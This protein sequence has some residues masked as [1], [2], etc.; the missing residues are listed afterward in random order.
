MLYVIDKFM[1]E[2][3]LHFEDGILEVEGSNYLAKK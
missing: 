1:P 2:V 3:K